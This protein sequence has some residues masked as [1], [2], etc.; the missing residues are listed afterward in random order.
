MVQ[1]LIL[2]R[3]KKYKRAGKFEQII[4]V[5]NCQWDIHQGGKIKHIWFVTPC[6]TISFLMNIK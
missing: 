2:N 1:W 3:L 6:V 5:D 4:S